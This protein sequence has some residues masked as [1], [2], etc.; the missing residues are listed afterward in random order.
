MSNFSRQV[1]RANPKL[2]PVTATLGDLKVVV[3]HS[4][5]I[6]ASVCVKAA[7]NSFVLNNQRKSIPTN[8]SANDLT[9]LTNVA[10]LCPTQAIFIYKKNKLIW[11][12]KNSTKRGAL[13]SDH[14]VM[15][16]EMVD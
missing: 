2:P 11:P 8:L 3:Y 15:R 16:L 9:T 13:P 7:L 14:H 10:R 5:C 1:A 12:T 4:R 6:G